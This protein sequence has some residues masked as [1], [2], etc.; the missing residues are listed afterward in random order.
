MR[1][2][3]TMQNRRSLRA[4]AG[5]CAARLCGAR[6]KKERYARLISPRPRGAACPSERFFTRWLRKYF[7]RKRGENSRSLEQ[8]PIINHQSPKPRTLLGY[9][10]L[11]IGYYLNEFHPKNRKLCV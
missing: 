3:R 11:V 7:C 8:S 6:R 1:E 5:N 2:A 9:W 10:I 4:R